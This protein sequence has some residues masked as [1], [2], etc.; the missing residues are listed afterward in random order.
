LLF[1]IEHFI[2]GPKTRVEH[3]NGWKT[4]FTCH[5][6][7]G[8]EIAMAEQGGFAKWWKLNYHFLAWMCLLAGVLALIFGSL[9]VYYEKKESPMGLVFLSDIGAWGYW[10][11]LFGTLAILAG[12]YYTYDHIAQ[13]RKF[14]KM[15]DGRG[16]AN[17]I[18]DLDEIERIAY[19][20]G[21]AF[22]MKVIERKREYRLK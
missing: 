15:M 20:L 1:E 16:R 3:F 9:G 8:V 2:R 22:E 13:L 12:G 21:P 14:E 5:V 6:L 7:G 18:K 11:I 19:G 10:I 4:F 17:F